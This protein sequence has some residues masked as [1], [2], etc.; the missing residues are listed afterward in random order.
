MRKLVEN[1]IKIQKRKEKKRESGEEKGVRWRW[2][3]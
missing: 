1:V 3:K 2:C